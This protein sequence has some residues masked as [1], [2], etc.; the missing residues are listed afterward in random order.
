M[1]KEKHSIRFELDKDTARRLFEA[2]RADGY[3]S[4]AE[5][6][7]EQIRNYFKEKRLSIE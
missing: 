1:T 7:R 5:W 2:I 6:V 4:F 3:R